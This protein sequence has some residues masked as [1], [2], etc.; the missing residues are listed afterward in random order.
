MFFAV[1]VQPCVM[2][3]YMGTRVHSGQGYTSLYKK[4]LQE[5]YPVETSKVNPETTYI[6][7]CNNS[8]TIF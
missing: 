6:I 3:T 8:I 2:Q 7:H 1:K 5:E 4:T